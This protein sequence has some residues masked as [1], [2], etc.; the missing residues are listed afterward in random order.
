MGKIYIDSKG[1]D[2]DDEDDVDDLSHFFAE[3]IFSDPRE[4]GDLNGELLPVLDLE[5][6]DHDDRALLDDV[7]VTEVEFDPVAK[8]VEVFYNV[9]YSAH[10]GCRDLSYTEIDDR[11]VIGT[12]EGSNWVFDEYVPPHRLSPSEEL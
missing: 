11:S 10:H 12:L 2:P 9:T 6:D 3:K 1:F 5:V 8:T 7:Q 4:G